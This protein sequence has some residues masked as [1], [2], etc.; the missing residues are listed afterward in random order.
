MLLRHVL[1]IFLMSKEDKSIS[2]WPTDPGVNKED[3][4]LPPIGEAMLSRKGHHCIRCEHSHTVDHFFLLGEKLGY[5]FGCTTS[6]FKKII[7]CCFV[8]LSVLGLPVMFVL[9]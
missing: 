6:K 8:N 7:T 4:F 2:C 5:F 1:Y 9:L 3:G